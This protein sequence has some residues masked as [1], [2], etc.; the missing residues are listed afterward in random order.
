MIALFSVE[1][2]VPHTQKKPLIA[3]TQNDPEMQTS[4][5]LLS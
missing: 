5:G 2:I 4:L 3:H 1:V